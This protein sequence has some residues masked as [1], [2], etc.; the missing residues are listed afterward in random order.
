MEFFDKLNNFH[1]YISP[2]TLSELESTPDDDLR[3][4]LEETVM[5]HMVLPVTEEIK[6][7]AMEYI[8]HS[9]IPEKYEEDAYHIAIA[10]INKMDYLLSWN[11]KHL[12]REKTRKIVEKVNM[13]NNLRM[14]DILTPAELL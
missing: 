2:V 14:I 7:L 12:V 10:V 8:K 9:V 11:F 5:G 3:E 6:L 1:I 13:M 4:K